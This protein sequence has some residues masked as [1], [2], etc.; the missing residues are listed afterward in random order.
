MIRFFDL[1]VVPNEIVQYRFRVW[2]A[3]P[4]DAKRQVYN[5][6]WNKDQLDSANASGMAGGEGEDASGVSG[7]TRGGARG[8]NRGQAT[9]L[10][11]AG[12]PFEDLFK[13]LDPDVRKRLKE[14]DTQPEMPQGL[15]F[16][17]YS[18][19]SNWSEL[20]EWISVPQTTGKVVAGRIDAGLEQNISGVTYF[21]DEP[22]VDI[23]VKKWDPALQVELPVSRKVFRSDVL[24]FRSNAKVI[25]PISQEIFDVKREL[26]EEGIEENG[27][28]FDANSFV[29]DMIGGEKM[30]FST[31]E[32]SYFEPSEILVMLPNGTMTVHNELT[33]RTE[34]RHGIF[35]D[36]ERLSDVQTQ[37]K[38]EKKKDNSEG[39]IGRAGRGGRGR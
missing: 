8:S 14:R 28:K 9:N 2:L 15:E 38:T 21:E 16:L 13:D 22:Q 5:R 32:K 37:A 7:T 29:V 17:K 20:T 36:D 26:S 27:V 3:D 31:A 12:N 18:R 35:A 25:N 39:G 24:N 4:N 6:L 1:S 10:A 33:D 19:P 23:L 34:Y 11:N 30:P